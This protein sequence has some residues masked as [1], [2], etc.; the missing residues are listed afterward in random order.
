MGFRQLIL[1]CHI[2]MAARLSSSLSLAATAAH[3]MNIDTYTLSQTPG[4]KGTKE[5]YPTRFF[6]YP[7]EMLSFD[8]YSPPITQLYSQVF[9]KGLDPVDLPAN[10]V[11]RFAGK[12]MAVCGFEMDQ[13]RQ[14][15]DASGKLTDVSVPINAVYNHHFESNMVG[16][17]ARFEKVSFDGPDD[18]RL[19]S[20]LKDMGGHGIPSLKDHWTVVSNED[21]E[22]VDED[23]NGVGA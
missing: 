1:L 22:S 7:R 15:K 18:P 23:D 5:K 3:N 17:G 14:V 20:L 10:I 11:K 13:V 4:A 16:S 2:L 6:D 21:E 9:W 12:G 19:K 8:V